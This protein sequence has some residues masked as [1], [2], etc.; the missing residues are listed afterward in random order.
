M[1]EYNIYDYPADFHVGEPKIMH[2]RKLNRKV[3]KTVQQAGIEIDREGLI[4]AINNDRKR[5]DEAYNKGYYD[6]KK[7]YEE[8]LK[9]IAELT[10]CLA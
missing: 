9:K 2:G 4:A 5:Y 3:I 8:K 10:G 6:C 1:K 7:E